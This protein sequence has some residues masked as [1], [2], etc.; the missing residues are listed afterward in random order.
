MSTEKHFSKKFLWPTL[1]LAGLNT[2][3]NKYTPHIYLHFFNNIPELE[4]GDSGIHDL[5]TKMQKRNLKVAVKH[6]VL[7][8]K[9]CYSGK[10]R[11]QSLYKI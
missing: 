7:G 5:L 4:E 6:A 11:L 1:F 8:V 9:S 10:L 2:T 3:F